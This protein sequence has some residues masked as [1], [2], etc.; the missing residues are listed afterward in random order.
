MK[1]V[2]LSALALSAAISF[3]A[4]T[5]CGVNGSHSISGYNDSASMNSSS[6]STTTTTTTAPADTSAANTSGT[7]NGGGT[8]GGGV[9][10]EN[11]QGGK[12]QVPVPADNA[13]RPVTEQVKVPK[14][15]NAEDVN[16]G[17]RTHGSGTPS[18][19]RETNGSNDVNNH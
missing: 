2:L 14:H 9:K 8:S 19:N 5:S 6:S 13:Q 18:T 3:E 4:C 7:N 17:A 10:V 16:S 12:E 11:V 15:G 1:I